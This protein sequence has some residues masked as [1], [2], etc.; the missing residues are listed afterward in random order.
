MAALGQ[1]PGERE[2]IGFRPWWMLAVLL[3]FYIFSTVDRIVLGMLVV[4]IQADLGLTDVQIGAIIGPGFA[5]AYSLFGL[6]FGW[7]SDRCPRRW[8][9]FIGMSLWSVAAAASGVARSFAALLGARVTVAAGE[10]ALS[11]AAY[12][13]ITDVFPVR[14]LALALSIYQMGAK[15]GVAIAF[16]I[17]GLA[18]GVAAHFAHLPLPFFG[19]LQA[20]QITLLLTGAPGVLLA[21]LVFTFSEPVRGKPE[22]PGDAAGQPA[23]LAYL[24]QHV[25]MLALMMAGTTGCAIALYSMVSW[26]PTMMQR[27]FGLLPQQYGPILSAIGTVSALTLVVKGMIVDWLYARGVVDAHLRFLSWLL[28]AAAPLS[29]LTFLARSKFGF[30]IPYALLDMIGG[31]F[32]IYITATIQIVVPAQFRGRVIAIFLGAITL[33][34]LGIGPILVAFLTDDLF[35]DPR[36]LGQSL[37]LVVGLSY[38]LGLIG[39]RLCL[40]RVRRALAAV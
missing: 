36:R 26:V 21:L 33:L 18:A 19:A 31:Q 40:P 38:V 2:R 17:A 16:S 32:V 24:R 27:S 8:V 6:L 37:A 39:L 35:G 15:F 14:R 34:G 1:G 7:A 28:A 11:P 23:F 20:W 5:V 12:A 25:A 13:L 10:A 29:A 9:I 30:L 4:P 3:L 22:R